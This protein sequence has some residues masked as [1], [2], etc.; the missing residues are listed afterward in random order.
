[1][2][3]IGAH[4]KLL[5]IQSNQSLEDVAYFCNTTVIEVCS[6]EE[7]NQLPNINSLEKLSLL[8]NIPV[9]ELLNRHEYIYR[10][11]IIQVMLYACALALYILILYPTVDNSPDYFDITSIFYGGY[12]PL[13]IVYYLLLSASIVYII[14]N[15]LYITKMIISIRLYHKL[16]MV[17][18]L[19]MGLTLVSFLFSENDLFDK[20]FTLSTVLVLN[21]VIYCYHYIGAIPKIKKELTLQS[22]RKYIVYIISIIYYLLAVSLF[23]NND[24]IGDL[25]Y[26][27]VVL[28]WLMISIIALGFIKEQ[29]FTN[30]RFVN[31]YVG[32]PLVLLFG[33]FIVSLLFQPFTGVT[34]WAVLIVLAIVT[35]LSAIPMWLINFDLWS[36]RWLS[37]DVTE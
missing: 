15:Y 3:D 34:F 7:E 27:Y 18:H 32:I 12:S 22:I 26:L 20:F 19:F 1:M 33:G 17:V 4:L 24:T 10:F 6:W 14:I 30:R 35:T 9:D 37:K 5:R 11:S 25:P 2:T 36:K 28:P 8:Y 31:L 13:R 16:G 23:I 29:W 21:I